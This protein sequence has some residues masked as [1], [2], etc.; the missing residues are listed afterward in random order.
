MS[1]M[2]LADYRVVDPVIT[3]VVHGY[4]NAES[5]APFVAPIVPV[6]VRAGKIIKYTKEQFAVLNTRRAPG[7]TIQRLPVNY[8]NEGYFLNQHAMGAEVTIEAYEEASNGEARVN[9]RQRAALRA[10]AAIAQSWED[11]VINTITTAS[12]YEAANVLTAAGTDKF[13]DPLSDI[14][15][16]IQEANELVRRQVGVYANSLLVSA[17]VYNAMRF[18]PIFRDRVKYTSSGSVNSDM[19][20]T[21]LDLPGGIKVS[22]R[23]KLNA[24]GQLVDMM[25]SGT[26]VLFYSPANGMPSSQYDSSLVYSLN[27]GA[28]IGTP[29]AFYT[30][31]LNGYPIASPERFDDD[32]KVFVTDVIAEQSI[33][34]VGLGETNKVGAAVLMTALI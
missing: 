27:E 19:L 26:A 15:T 13:S 25:P 12:L 8:T 16:Y 2:N 7:T 3:S 24:N 5:V 29:S 22:R 33:M 10:T 20:A 32:R 18:N 31:T 34:P 4:A 11:E 23:L 28:D 14:E 17:D 21:W 6:D 1:G 30:Y 9:L